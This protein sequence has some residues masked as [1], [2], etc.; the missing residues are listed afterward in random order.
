[1]TTDNRAK[2][3]AQIAVEQQERVA[4]CE[5]GARLVGRYAE[6]AGNHH[7]LDSPCRVLERT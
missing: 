5:I 4:H 1:M 2:L 7:A 6:L 3:H